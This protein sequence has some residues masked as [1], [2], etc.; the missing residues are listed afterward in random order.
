MQQAWGWGLGL[1][2]L[3]N[4]L[5]PADEVE[6]GQWVLLLAWG[7]FIG[8]FVLSLTDHAQNGFFYS[9]EWVPVGVAAFVVGW[10]ALPIFRPTPPRYL[11]LAGLV[12]IVAA[13]TGL[14]GFVFHVAPV[15][16]EDAGTLSERIIYGAPIFAPLLFPNLAL[17]G[18][19]GVWDLQAKG[20]VAR[21]PPEVA[22]ERA[23]VTD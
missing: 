2:V 14:A 16:G 18:L 10:L 9:T 4:R 20:H 12:L 17:L 6:W 15:I 7:G 5:V 19:L 13:V 11:W 23:G 21:V 22:D 8:N 1:L 3:L